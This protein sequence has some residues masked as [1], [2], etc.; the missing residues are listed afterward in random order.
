MDLDYVLLGGDSSLTS[1][2]HWC[3]AD[4]PMD[5]Y[6]GRGKRSIRLQSL[7]RH[8]MSALLLGLTGRLQEGFPN[9]CLHVHSC[10]HGH[11]LDL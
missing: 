10:K 9:G 7:S 1:L 2:G 5:G 6:P 4:S 3:R 8:F 11:L